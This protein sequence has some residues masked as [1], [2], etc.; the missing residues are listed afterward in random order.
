[1]DKLLGPEKTTGR[2][3]T[4]TFLADRTLDQSIA[5]PDSINYEPKGVGG[6][7]ARGKLADY[8]GSLPLQSFGLVLTMLQ[9]G[10]KDQIR[11]SQWEFTALRKCVNQ[12]DHSYK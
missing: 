10:N 3:V 6:L 7:T 5:K 2:Q 9:A 4:I 12:G 1:M 11:H 8:I